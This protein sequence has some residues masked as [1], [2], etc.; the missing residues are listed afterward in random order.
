MSLKLFPYRSLPASIISVQ[1]PPCLE[2]I[3]FIGAKLS[4]SFTLNLSLEVEGVEIKRKRQQ[5]REGLK[6]KIERLKIFKRFGIM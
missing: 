5:S 3:F 6:I 1:Y 4:Q 2:E